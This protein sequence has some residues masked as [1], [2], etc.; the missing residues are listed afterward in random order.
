MSHYY[1][2]YCAEHG[3]YDADIDGDQECEKCVTEGKTERQVMQRRIDELERRLFAIDSAEMPEKVAPKAYMVTC[4]GEPSVPAEFYITLFGAQHNRFHTPK[5]TPLFHGKHYDQLR[6]F[7]QAQ[8]ARADEN[9]RE[10]DAWMNIASEDNKRAN[11]FWV[12]E[13]FKDGRS[14]GYWTGGSSRDFTTDINKAVQFR[15]HDDAFWVTRGWH[16]DDTKISEH[17]MIDAAIAAGKGE[18]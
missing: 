14:D 17:I 8:S 9:A 12:V 3:D 7:A 16:W 4:E 1:T 2:R 13:R 11:S 15:R 18:V 5:I 10:R 6:T